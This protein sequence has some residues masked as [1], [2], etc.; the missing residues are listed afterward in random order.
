MSIKV[1]IFSVLAITAGTIMIG[2]SVFGYYYTKDRIE[3]SLENDIQTR[4]TLYSEFVD[5]IMYERIKEDLL[6]SKQDFL[7]AEWIDDEE[8]QALLQKFIRDSEGYHS[9]LYANVSPK[10]KDRKD[11]SSLVGK[12]TVSSILDMLR[13][14]VSKTGWYQK[15]LETKEPFVSD[16]HHAKNSETPIVTIAIP[17]FDMGKEM[18]GILALNVDISRILG[19]LMKEAQESY[20]TIGIR[21]VPFIINTAGR[22][23]THPD[24]SFI[25]KSADGIIPA[26]RIREISEKQTKQSFGLFRAE[27]EQGTWIVG[28]AR[29]NGYRLFKADWVSLL[30]IDSSFVDAQVN[31]LK[32]IYLITA[33]S[34]ILIVLG[35]AYFIARALT[36]PLLQSVNFAK[37]ISEGDFTQT[38][39]I[40][41]KDEIGT[42][43]RGMNTMAES[44]NKMFKEIGVISEK[45][46]SSSKN[47]SDISQKVSSETDQTSDNSK[48]VTN[49]IEAL[50]NSMNS[51]QMD[52][53]QTSQNINMVASAVEEM[54]AT[55]NEITGNSSK[56]QQITGNAVSQAREISE[57]IRDLGVATKEIDSIS[58]TITEISDQTN[59]LALNATIEAARA[60]E[61][62]KGFAVVANEIKELSNQTADSVNKIKNSI[63]GIQNVSD[64]TIE[65]IGQ[66][67][68]VID[69]TNEIVTSI[70]SAIEEQSVTSK[71]VA[72]NV[73][74]ASSRVHTVTEHVVKSSKATEGISTDMKKIKDA[75]E[76]ISDS[77]QQVNSSV[78]E[79][80]NLA[81]SLNEMISQY[82]V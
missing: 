2:I 76:A 50:N 8:K 80:S 6:F 66:I 78:K 60:G 71:E 73:A 31:N 13:V 23:V 68:G 22:I 19:S 79:L 42:L 52:M 47:L 81:D 39:D 28:Y 51:V 18:W 69:E 20:K 32:M 16:V 48:L 4:I 63:E 58:A 3:S 30:T 14:D 82:K 12:I 7:Y 56:A 10:V 15:C 27:N 29:H 45:L 74:E 59:L 41:K 34:V 55:I 67:I 24:A 40:Q 43:A 72:G 75:S 9:G 17:V 46:F 38:L 57:F 37:S 33:A 49:T 5:R 1:K 65:G 11:K 26:S 77:T 36:L 53:E 62:G 35:I 70:A 21:A 64:R 61:A 25:M 44:L 54:S